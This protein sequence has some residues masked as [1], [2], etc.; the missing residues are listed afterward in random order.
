MPQKRF[1]A[2][3]LSVVTISL[4][5]IL[6]LFF[7]FCIIYTLYFRSRIRSQGLIQLSYFNGPWIIRIIYIF[8]TLWWGFGEIARLRILRRNGIIS[9]WQVN[10]CKYYIVSNL[11]FSEPCFFLVLVFLLHASLQ[12]SG[13]LNQNWNVKTVGFVLLY[14]FPMFVQLPSYFFEAAVFSNDNIAICSYPLLST[15]FLGIFATVLTG[16]LLWLGRRILHLVINKGLQKRV[17][18]LIFSISSL[19]PLRALLLGLS[20]LVR[21]ENAAFDGIVFLAFLSFLCCAFVGIC[22]LVYL[23]ITDSLVLGTDDTVSLIAANDDSPGRNSSDSENRRG[24]ISFRVKG[25]DGEE[26]CE[27]GFV[28]LSL[29]SE[30]STPPRSPRVVGWP[31][32]PPPEP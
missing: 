2:D 27:E 15:I 20:V 17:Y 14:S 10:V 18:T 19:F 29:F 13:A 32:I 6:A 22:I 30:R 7:L 31:M 9:K 21:P 26:G 25:K 5:S 3:A 11:G 24:S 8:L 16:Y 12:R 23:P 28:E 1:I 4:V